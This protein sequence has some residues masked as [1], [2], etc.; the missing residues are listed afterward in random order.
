MQ[1]EKN[2]F[3]VY[4]MQ[5]QLINTNSR[6]IMFRTEETA[7]ASLRK[8]IFVLPGEPGKN[9][10]LVGSFNSWAIG[11]C[12]MEYSAEERG[13]MCELLLTPGVYEYKFVCDGCWL[14]D[15]DNPDFIANDFGT[16][17][18]VLKIR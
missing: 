10:F 4:I 18:S 9:L 8:V 1:I 11:A 7:S 12:A 13:Y 16:L 15:N 14:L 2:P 5:L 3:A 6:E 17:N